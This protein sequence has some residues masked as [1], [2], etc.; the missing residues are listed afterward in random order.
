VTMPDATKYRATV[1]ITHEVEVE[2]YDSLGVPH[3]ALIAVRDRA[4]YP[5]LVEV[6]NVERIPTDT[7]EEADRV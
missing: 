2:A 3:A 4:T 6:K 7:T 1:V 5:A